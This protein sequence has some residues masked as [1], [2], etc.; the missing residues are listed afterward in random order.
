MI[1]G[2]S[3]IVSPDKRVVILNKSLNA[4]C[5][6]VND[7]ISQRAYV[8]IN[9]KQIQFIQIENKSNDQEQIQSDPKPRP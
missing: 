4:H 5:S 2:L 7:S 9:G 3:V 6:I 1:V 8:T